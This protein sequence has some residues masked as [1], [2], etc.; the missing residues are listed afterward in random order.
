MN[1]KI[2]KMIEYPN[3]GISSKVIVKSDDL[4]VTLFCMAKY[5]D[6]SDHTST[7]AGTVYVIEGDGF[8]NLEG[9]DIEM[10]SGTLIYMKK[11]A[12]H[13]LRANENTTF[14]LTLINN[15]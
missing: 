15:I 10:K 13:S 1:K 5:T 7:R 3:E 11:N 9:E 2:M 14:V 12:V 6:I 8:F 4:D